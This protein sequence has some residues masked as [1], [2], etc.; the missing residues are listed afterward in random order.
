MPAFRLRKRHYRLILCVLTT[1]FDRRR[2]HR[3]ILVSPLHA[4]GRRTGGA[5]QVNYVDS[6]KK[7]GSLLFQVG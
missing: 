4:M 1:D 7:G 6:G 2:R 5:L 3:N